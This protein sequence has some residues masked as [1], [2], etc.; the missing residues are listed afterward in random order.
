M[1]DQLGMTELWTNQDTILTMRLNTIKQR[2]LD[3]Y[4]QSWYSN[5]NNSRRQNTYCIFK[6]TFNLEP[7]L[8]I[9]T[10]KRLRS[11]LRRYRLSSH[12]LK[13]ERGRYH[14]IDRKNRICKYCNLKAIENEYHFL[15]VCPLYRNIR[16]QCF[17]S[18]YC[19]WP[20]INKFE[21]LLSKQNKKVTM[22]LFKYIY[23]AMHLRYLLD[24]YKNSDIV[25]SF[26]KCSR[27]FHM[28]VT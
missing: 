18:Y 20:T 23:H 25:I 12:K 9:I 8:D 26:L 6:H 2:L 14:N 13:I 15:L 5:I 27:L 11:A 22:N 21:T 16:K 28:Y 17:T 24:N 10:N 1:L 4:Y 7:Y 19:S 3:H